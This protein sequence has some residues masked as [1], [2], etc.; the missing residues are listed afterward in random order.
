MRLDRV[1]VARGLGSRTQAARLL[2][3]GRVRVDGVV[4]RDAKTDVP[5][6]VTVWLDDVAHAPAPVLVAW[7]KPVG[8]LSTVRD[9]WGREG[10]EQALPAAWRAALHPVGRLDQDTS[11]LLLFSGDGALTQRLLHP[12][13]AVP[14]TYEATVAVDPP[15][16]LATRL[17]EGVSTGEGVVVAHVDAIDGRRVRLTVHEG[18]HR[19]VRRMLHNAGAS[20]VTLHRVAYGPVQLGALQVGAV[21]VVD[22]A[23]LARVLAI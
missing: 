20:V 11:G 14:R 3:Q 9:P 6:D 15:A 5:E 19:M 23:T 16:D 8:V 17:S 1:M 2:A 18:K 22:D 10:L 21:A 7:H 12:R 4:V 13:R